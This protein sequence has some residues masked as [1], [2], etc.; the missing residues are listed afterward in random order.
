M[1]FPSSLTHMVE[2]VQGDDRV[3]LAFNTFPAGY[4]GDESS[5][6]ELHLKE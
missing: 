3:S 1:L 4:V 2:T 6:T 5:L